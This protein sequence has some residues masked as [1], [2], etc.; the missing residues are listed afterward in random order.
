MEMGRKNCQ[1]TGGHSLRVTLTTS[2]SRDAIAGINSQIHFRIVVLSAPPHK[3]DITANFA[4]TF[5]NNKV[6]SMC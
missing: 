4:Y 1:L 2:D 5:M 6:Q 3:C